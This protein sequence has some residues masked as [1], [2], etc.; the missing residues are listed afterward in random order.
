MV[1]GAE[2]LVHLASGEIDAIPLAASPHGKAEIQ[3]AKFGIIVFRRYGVEHGTVV[4]DMV[5]E[6]EIITGNEI[7]ASSLDSL[8]VRDSDLLG[9]SQKFG[10]RDFVAPVG[11][12]G[13]LD[14]SLVTNPGETKDSR[15]NHFGVILRLR[16]VSSLV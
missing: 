7:Y 12:D 10:F 6:G 9:G 8:P 16:N 13:F 4:E 14:L 3:G 2:V 1:I 5:I 11:F 15:V